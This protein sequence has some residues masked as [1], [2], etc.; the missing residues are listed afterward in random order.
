M[1]RWND[2]MESP[3]LNKSHWRKSGQWFALQRRH[4]E[5]IVADTEVAKA[6]KQYVPR[7][8]NSSPMLLTPHG[9]AAG[10][11]CTASRSFDTARHML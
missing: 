1:R 3:S 4:A 8:P 9:L 6:F 11:Y 7:M 5:I 10:L 2:A